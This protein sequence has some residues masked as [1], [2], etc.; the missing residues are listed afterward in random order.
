[1]RA[2]RVAFVGRLKGVEIRGSL[3]PLGGV[4]GGHRLYVNGGMRA[5]A[6]V[7]VGDKVSFELRATPADVVPVPADLATALRRE[8]TAR[9]AFD[10]LPPSHRR[11]LLRYVDDART[12]ETRQ[13][14]L[15]RTVEHVLGREAS[16][17]SGGE[18]A[19]ESTSAR[20]DTG[21]PLWTCPR[22]GNQF[23]NRNQFHSCASYEL[24]DLFRGK[25]PRIRQLF[26]RFRSMVE[27]LGPVKV[28]PYQDK[29]GF[30][31]RVRF[32][33]A[34]PRKEW[35]EIGFWLPRRVSSPRFRRVETITPRAHVHLVRITHPSE[36]DREVQGW[37]REAYAV[38][39]QEH[40]AR[41]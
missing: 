6:G 37:L 17:R 35:L 21:Q 9:A 2:G 24:D 27:R 26:D 36:L 29:V 3:V 40:L 4:G 33:G 22:C 30:M 5:A 10:A 13:R 1:M 28:L 14:R 39:R 41:C 38:G 8:K 20:A 7:G 12:P 34:V 23:V 25:P 19:R 11:Q 31:V 18:S 32:A 16:G 15:I